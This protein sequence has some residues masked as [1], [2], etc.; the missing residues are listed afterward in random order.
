MANVRVI[1]Q[2]RHGGSEEVS[3]EMYK[4][5]EAMLFKGACQDPLRAQ[6]CGQC[7]LTELYTQ[8]PASLW[9]L[10]NKGGAGGGS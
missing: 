9:K 7:G 1:Y 6:V 3:L 4:D 10:Y 8:R 2:D 5:S